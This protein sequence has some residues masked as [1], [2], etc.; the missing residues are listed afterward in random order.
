M[1]NTL[2]DGIKKD[3]KCTQCEDV[4]SMD[5]YEDAKRHAGSSNHVVLGELYV[6]TKP[7]L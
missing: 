5:S 4:T 1:E 2:E 7:E 3:Y 6:P